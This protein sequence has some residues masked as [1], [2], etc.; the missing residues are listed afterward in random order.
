MAG[1]SDRA[2]RL[3]CKKYGAEYMTTE[4]VSAK[5]I[6][7]KDKKTIELCYIREDEMPCA[8]QLFGH[9]ESVMAEA[10]GMICAG[11]AKGALPTAIDINMGCPVPKIT[12]NH[13]GSYLMK[14]PTLVFSLVRA[15]VKASNIPVTVKIRAGYDENNINACEVALA[16][17]EGGAS[18]ICVH[19]RTKTQMY[20]GR[21]DREIIAKVK[22]C[23]SV[24]V[25]ANGDIID[26]QSAL[27]MIKETN[28]DGIAIG[29][30]AV[31]N[32][33]VFKQIISA[34]EGNEIP[35]VSEKQR[36]ETAL[37]Q[38]RLAIEDKGE[39]LAV[40]ESRKQIAEYIKGTSGAAEIRAKINAAPT[41]EAVEAILNE[42]IK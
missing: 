34:I 35:T 41:Y 21:A 5:A 24:P 11:Y 22:D 37:L 1:Y 20:S 6:T 32:P 15:T 39:R 26:A 13:E 12:G 3:V 33:F 17:Q 9:E 25:I 10:A 2:M 7:Y 28:C 30:G 40:F 16:A 14:D 38:L 23:V 4:M 36:I 19:G 31:G 27:S 18:L 8:L 29:R 42:K